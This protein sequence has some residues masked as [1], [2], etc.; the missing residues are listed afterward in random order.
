MSQADSAR[1][2]DISNIVVED[3]VGEIRRRRGGKFIGIL[4]CKK[5]F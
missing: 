5:H 4:S 1:V 3:E 2:L